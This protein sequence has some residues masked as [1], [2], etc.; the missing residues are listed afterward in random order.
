[1]ADLEDIMEANG[2][3]LLDRIN[4]LKVTDPGSVEEENVVKGYD[5]IFK[6][7]VALIKAYEETIKND[8]DEQIAKQRIEVEKEKINLENMLEE[9]KLE[10]EERSEKMKLVKEWGSVAAAVSAPI[11]CE[12]IKQTFHWAVSKK[13]LIFEETGSITST[14]GKAEFRK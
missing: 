3:L 6:N 10:S 11:V 13:V 2:E 14:V 4:Q 9:K 12:I 7:H 8:N 5:T 1:M